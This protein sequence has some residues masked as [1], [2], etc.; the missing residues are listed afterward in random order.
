MC[1][2]KTSK[3]GNRPD[4]ISV[5]ACKAVF[6]LRY[7]KDHSVLITKTKRASVQHCMDAR[8]VLFYR[9]NVIVYRLTA[10]DK[11][12]IHGRIFVCKLA[13]Q[14]FGISIRNISTVKDRDV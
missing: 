7:T 6:D 2:F 10:A 13:V 11:V 14:S 8:I 5:Y 3:H 9:N 12:D 1:G 4:S